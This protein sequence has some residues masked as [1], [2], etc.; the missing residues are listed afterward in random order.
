MA[1]EGANP[2][3]PSFEKPAIITYDSNELGR[4][5]ALTGGA[6]SD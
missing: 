6:A 3:K 5:T 2:Q 4:E 1:D